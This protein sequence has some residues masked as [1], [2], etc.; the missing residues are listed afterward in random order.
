MGGLNSLLFLII[1]GTGKSKIKVPADLVPLPGF[2]KSTFLLCPLVLERKEAL[3]S[4]SVFVFVLLFF[5]YK[6]SN[7][8]MGALT[9]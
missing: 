2:Q 1:L 7:F 9:S 4:L 5:F 3:V 6:P 8:I